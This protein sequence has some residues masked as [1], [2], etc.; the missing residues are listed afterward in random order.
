MLTKKLTR[1]LC[2]SRL[3]FKQASTGANHESFEDEFKNH[4]IP[5]T[6]LQRTVLTFGSAATSIL[7]PYRADM[8]ACLSET[9]GRFPRIKLNAK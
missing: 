2:T 9:T 4:H 1:L 5:T 3:S 7:D 8:I 6:F